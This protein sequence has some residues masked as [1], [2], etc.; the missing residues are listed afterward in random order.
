MRR[1]RCDI[2][3]SRRCDPRQLTLLV[4]VEMHEA[5]LASIFKRGVA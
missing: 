1:L 2:C 4:F 5:W 3:G